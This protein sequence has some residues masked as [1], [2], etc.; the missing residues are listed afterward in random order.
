[1]KQL[2]SLIYGSALII[3]FIFLFYFVD[4]Y[5]NTSPISPHRLGVISIETSPPEA[6]IFIN[7]SF[8][9][10]TPLTSIEVKPGNA[11][12]KVQKEGFNTLIR[13][14]FINENEKARFS[15]KLGQIS[16]PL[17]KEDQKITKNY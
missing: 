11:V 12:I 17:T 16:S 13:V 4:I 3:F 1:M 10:F 14:V 6:H 2:S 8:M 15:F 5:H 7:D 9:G